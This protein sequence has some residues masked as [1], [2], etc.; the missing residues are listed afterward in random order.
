MPL[1]RE[2]KFS[3]PEGYVPSHLELG[4]TLDGVQVGGR[5]VTVATGRV[6]RYSD[7]Y[8]DTPEDALATGGWALRT[9]VSAVGVT[10]G[11]KGDAKVSGAMHE[12]FELEVPGTPSEP[13]DS[14][15][16][17]S[18]AAAPSWPDELVTALGGAVPAEDLT[19]LEPRVVLDVTRV[20]HALEF[21]APGSDTAMAMLL[22]FDEVSCRLPD[23]GP[24]GGDVLAG[25]QARFH[26]VELEAGPDTDARDLEGV[27]EAL[28]QLLPL[29]ASSVAK[30]DRAR[31]L[32]APFMRR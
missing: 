14:P 32:L 27:A 12:R 22:C 30:S 6:A 7:T 20:S 15:A 29:S 11:L 9:R 26:E 21:D 5:Q 1:E 10:Y 2:L 28:A 24:G 23:P 16:G 13:P 8:Y 3:S 19:R 18:A 31:A 25:T 4:Y 17:G